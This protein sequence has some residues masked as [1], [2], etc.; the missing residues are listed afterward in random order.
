VP[1]ALETIRRLDWRFLLPDP[2]LGRVVYAGPANHALLLALKDFCETHVVTELRGNGRSTLFDVAVVCSAT[3]TQVEQVL[4]WL[5]PGGVLYWEV[6]RGRRQ[7]AG[8]RKH[9]YRDAEDFL[10]RHGFREIA[11][12]WHRPNFERALEI[13][14]LNDPT[15]LD[16][17]FSRTRSD[18]SG[19]LKIRFGRLLARTGLLPY[20]LSSVSLVARRKEAPA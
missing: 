9:P 5:K 8:L 16:Y 20:V 14:A 2:N 17:Y 18:F 13:V 10:L 1:P 15:A 4:P 12:Y 3:H 6:P 19:R 11:C 7:A